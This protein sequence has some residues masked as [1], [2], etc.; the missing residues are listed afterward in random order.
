MTVT[1]GAPQRFI[2]IVARGRLSSYELDGKDG[3]LGLHEC[4]RLLVEGHCHV[5]LAL[6]VDLQRL[7]SQQ[8]VTLLGLLCMP[9]VHLLELLL[10]IWVLRLQ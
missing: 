2:L 4:H 5:G 8:R 6:Q 9:L 3:G 1:F 7:V 10:H